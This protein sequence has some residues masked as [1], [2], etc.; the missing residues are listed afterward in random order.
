[1]AVR[2]NGSPWKKDGE[3]IYPYKLMGNFLREQN[4]DIV[5]SLCQYGMATCGNGAARSTAIAG[6]P[7]A[8]SWTPGKA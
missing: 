1:M 5:F 6:A 4:R 3:A 7:P 8:T 2:S